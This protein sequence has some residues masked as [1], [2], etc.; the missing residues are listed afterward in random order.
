MVI[1][2]FDGQSLLKAPLSRERFALALR[3]GQGRALLHVRKF[4]LAGVADLVLEACLHNQTYDVQCEDSRATWLFEMF[5]DAPDYP[6]FSK[7]ICESL[8]SAEVVDPYDLSQLCD[9]A[10]LM[11]QGGDEPALRAL[12]IR[13]LRQVDQETDKDIGC[14]ALVRCEGAPAL[15]ELARRFGVQLRA[16]VSDFHIP[17]LYDLIDDEFFE[18]QRAALL[19]AETNDANVRAWCDL[20]RDG[21]EDREPI[22]L[23]S[24]EERKAKARERSRARFPLERILEDGAAAKGEFPGIFGTFGQY[25]T[26][27]EQKLIFQKYLAETDDAVRLRWLWVFDRVPMPELHASLWTL[28]ESSDSKWRNAAMRA[29]AQF[30][31]DAVGRFGRTFVS[32]MKFT[33][34]AFEVLTLFIRNFRSDDVA[35]I[36]N[37]L[38]HLSPDSDEAHCLAWNL[39]YVSEANLSEHVGGLL[40]WVYEN[41]PCMNCRSKAVELLV[42]A[43]ILTEDL[44]LECLCDAD[45]ETRALARKEK[46]IA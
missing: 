1:F 29:L 22:P 12:R 24:P 20:V 38:E 16:G 40:E 45:E 25:S 17:V 7:T 41:T 8:E 10:A 42:T 6:E 43:G 34:D 35:I 32:S 36:L 44:R 28:A 11:A 5:R 30:K 37:G 46:E 39:L 21:L 31:D 13:V 18:S 15:V 2:D 26:E 33:A 19:E 27:E 14:A 4:G 3:R 9:L 23:K